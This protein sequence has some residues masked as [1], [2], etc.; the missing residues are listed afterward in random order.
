MGLYRLPPTRVDIAIA[1]SVSHYATP[2]TERV[3]QLVT[4]GADEHLLLAL[5]AGWWVYCRNKSPHARRNSNHIFLTA[6]AVSALPHLIKSIAAA[7]PA[8]HHR[9]SP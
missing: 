3:A 5:A 1:D 9:P 4:F 2:H 8:H 7:G 6:V